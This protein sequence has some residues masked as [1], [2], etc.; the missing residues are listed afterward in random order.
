MYIW[1]FRID[2]CSVWSP[3]MVDITADKT[4]GCIFLWLNQF[5]VWIILYLKKIK[6]K[7][8]FLK[9]RTYIMFQT[10]IVISIS[11]AESNT[12]FASI[13][14]FSSFPLISL[15]GFFQVFLAC[16][17]IV[18]LSKKVQ[19]VTPNASRAKRYLTIEEGSLKKIIEPK[20]LR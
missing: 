2:K 6:F 4:H 13:F 3:K 12:N 7:S 14:F 1:R 16:F 11:S 18:Q 19:L 5:N 9:S 8:K 17:C 15:F 10:K 20:N